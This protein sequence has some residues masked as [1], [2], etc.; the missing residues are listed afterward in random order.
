[1]K[2]G[3]LTNCFNKN[4]EEGIK[5]ASKMGFTGV[6][7]YATTGDFAFDKMTEQ[8]KA[9]Y[10]K[11]LADNNLEISAICGDMGGFGFEIEEDNPERIEKTKRIVD[12]AVEFNT[13]VITSHIGVIPEDQNCKK[14]QVMLNALSEIGEYAYSKGVTIAIETGPEVAKTLYNFVSKIKRGVGVNLDPANFIMVTG[15]D[16]A[17]AVYLLKDY[18]VHT[19]LKDGKKLKES[20]AEKIYHAFAI[21]GIEALNAAD[22]FIETPVGQGNV[23]FDKYIKALNEVGYN[24]Y[25]TVEREAGDNIEEDIAKG[26]EYIKQFL[27]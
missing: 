10:K 6:Q 23:D 16:P 7:I 1:M 26:V 2:L 3:V 25:L 22:Y 12:L 15:Q 18:I 9:N 11:M 4:T 27:A 19:H 8:D 13:K 21:G 14:F 17:E 20:S 24:G 5:I